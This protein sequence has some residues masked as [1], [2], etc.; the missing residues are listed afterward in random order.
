MNKELVVVLE[1]SGLEKSQAE[2]VLAGFNN[3][4][5]EVKGHEKRAKSIVV[6]S[7]DQT[8]QIKEARSI[9]LELK[10]IRVNAEKVRK[11]R[12][13]FFLRGGKAIDGIANVLKALI[14]PLEEHLAKQE[15]FI[16][17]MEDERKERVNTERITLLNNYVEDITVYNLKDMTDGAFEVLLRTSKTAWQ[18]QRDA[19]KK[20]EEERIAKEK[21]EEEEYE[22]AKKENAKLLK[23]AEAKEKK[24]AKERAE[25]EKKLE[26]EREKARKEAEARERV[27]VEL[28]AKQE[29]EIRAKIE[30]EQAENQA[31]EEKKKLDKQEKYRAFRTENGWT[32]KNKLDFKEENTGKEI[33]LWKKVGVFN[34][35]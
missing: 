5:E 6:T 35:K 21:A 19:E 30:K 4:F 28:K 27:E 2:T 9:R 32:E 26:A 24:L 12:K 29:A 11:E 31:N 8:E 17:R 18:S 7:A 33:I 1:Q 16:E 23:E 25:Q 15:N 10:D 34:L 22:R 3:F 14:V 20:A 13:E